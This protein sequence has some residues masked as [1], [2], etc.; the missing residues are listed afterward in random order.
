M[1]ATRPGAVTR[2]I[3]DDELDTDPSYS[4]PPAWSDKALTNPPTPPLE[5]ARLRE[6]I[7]GLKAALPLAVGIVPFMLIYGVLTR[8]AGLTPVEAQAMTLFV[9]SGAQLVAAQMLVGGAPGVV[10]VTAGATMNLRH[11]IYSAALAP[12]LTRLSLGWR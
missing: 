12:Y 5:Y 9:F 8:A 6:Y 2:P 7:A 1:Y 11:A 10:I 3:L 4:L